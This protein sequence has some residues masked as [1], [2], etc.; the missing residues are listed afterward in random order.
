[1]T[2]ESRELH[3]AFGLYKFGPLKRTST[4]RY[5]RKCA[6]K[7]RRSGLF[8]IMILCKIVGKIVNLIEKV[9]WDRFRAIAYFQAG[10]LVIPHT[11]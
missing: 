11:L 3:Q 2:T 1:M 6:D 9:N 5:T 7:Y 4:P 8:L 10:I